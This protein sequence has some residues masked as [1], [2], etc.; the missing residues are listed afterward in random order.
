VPPGGVRVFVIETDEQGFERLFAA[1]P[2]TDLKAAERTWPTGSKASLS[3]ALTT[4]RSPIFPSAN[5]LN[6]GACSIV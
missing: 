4:C 5:N 2:P 6:H 1:N 3:K